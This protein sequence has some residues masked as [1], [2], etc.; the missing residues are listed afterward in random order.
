MFTKIYKKI[1]N[2]SFKFICRKVMKMYIKDWKGFRGVCTL[3]DFEEYYNFEKNLDID[4]FHDKLVHPFSFCFNL[5]LKRSSEFIKYDLGY[6][7]AVKGIQETFQYI[8]SNEYDISSYN[9]V[10]E[11]INQD[12]EDGM[13]Y[14]FRDYENKK[15][16]G[17]IYHDYIEKYY[18]FGYYKKG[19]GLKFDRDLKLEEC[20]NLS[21]C[22]DDKN[23]NEYEIIKH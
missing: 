10:L 14:F 8:L 4:A 18:E 22:Y 13:F 11:L 9:F 20:L 1:L 6:Y 12:G 23:Y 21:D 3:K 5:Y 2:C 7:G 15:V 19:E 16:F 17:V